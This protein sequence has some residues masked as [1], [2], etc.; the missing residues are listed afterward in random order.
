ML[1]MGQTQ[2][3]KVI[4]DHTDLELGGVAEFKP[5]SGLQT[6]SMSRQLNRLFFTTPLSL[7]ISKFNLLIFKKQ[8]R[9]S[10]VRFLCLVQE[11]RT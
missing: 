8:R 6:P 3:G 1:D 10:G 4:Q 7:A 9:K 5:R 2:K 11:I